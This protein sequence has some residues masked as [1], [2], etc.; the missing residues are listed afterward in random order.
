MGRLI[1]CLAAIAALLNLITMREVDGRT[2]GAAKNQLVALE[3]QSQLTQAID[4]SIERPGKVLAPTERSIATAKSN[5]ELL[6]A[7]QIGASGL[8]RFK[9]VV[10]GVA[11]PLVPSQKDYAFLICGN[12][13]ESGYD[14]F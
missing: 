2:F 13:A 12:V 7:P 11:G 9:P 10:T 14:E 3:V 1:Q 4:S 5:L 6:K 8:A